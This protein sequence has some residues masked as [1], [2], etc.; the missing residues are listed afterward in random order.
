MKSLIFTDLE[1]YEEFIYITNFNII[2]LKDYHKIKLH[3]IIYTIKYNLNSD[4][5]KNIWHYVEN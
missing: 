1:T 3:F 2:S 5:I 4:I